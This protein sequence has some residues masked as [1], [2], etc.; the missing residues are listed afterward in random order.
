MPFLSQ[1]VVGTQG[2]DSWSALSEDRRAAL[3]DALVKLA[4]AISATL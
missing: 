1:A 2:K 4:E 3:R